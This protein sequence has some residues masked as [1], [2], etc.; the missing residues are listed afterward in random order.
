MDVFVP[1]IQVLLKIRPIVLPT[2]DHLTFCCD[3]L[4][5]LLL[6]VVS[7]PF[8]QQLNARDSRLYVEARA[9]Y[10]QKKATMLTA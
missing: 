2:R 5:L 10:D 1:R 7:L 9:V 3:V 6:S 4:S 8:V